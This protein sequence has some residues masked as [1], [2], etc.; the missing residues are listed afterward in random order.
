MSKH[1]EV[2]I[3]MLFYIFFTDT[4]AHV[5]NYTYYHSVLFMDYKAGQFIE[6]LGPNCGTVPT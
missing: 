3:A 4:H 1:L 6:P 2:N 5:A